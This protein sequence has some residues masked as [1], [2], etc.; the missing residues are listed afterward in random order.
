MNFYLCPF[1]YLWSPQF[2]SGAQ[3]C[4]TLCDPMNRSTPGLPVH[5]Q[6]PGLLKLMSIESVMPSSHLILCRPL[7]LLPPIP[8]S[9]RVFSSESA[10]RIRWPKY[11]S[12]TPNWNVSWCVKLSLDPPQQT[13]SP[14]SLHRPEWAHLRVAC[15]VVIT[16]SSQTSHP[17]SAI[18]SEPQILIVKCSWNKWLWGHFQVTLTF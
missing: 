11:W 9:I 6:L 2:S 4:P 5:H 18:L 15:H 16:W 8:R 10:L 3:S 17:H 13:R 14:Q 1:F 12:L 7:L